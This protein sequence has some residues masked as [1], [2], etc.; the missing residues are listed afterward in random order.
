MRKWG[1]L[2]VSG[3]VLAACASLSAGEADKQYELSLASGAGLAMAWHGGPGV[4]NAIFVQRLDAAAKPKSAPVRLT[5]G[6]K[7]AYEP[8]LQ[9]IGGDL[10]VVWYE[11]DK[12]AGSTR[13]FLA[14]LNA[15]GGIVW[16]SP[17]DA[18]GG[19]ARNAVVRVSG[20]KIYAAWIETGANGPEVFA[21]TLS[22]QGDA[23]GKALRVGAAN[24]DTWNLNATTDAGGVLYLAYDAQLGTKGH[25]LQVVAVDGSTVKSV[26]VSADDGRASL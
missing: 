2:L 5:D 8:D 4:E 10:L 20:D 24:K 25:E 6:T 23:A 14:R 11:K 17:L 3:L 7:D 19:N 13:A 21:E 18:G 9:L 15:A 16:K 1:A 26:T 22:A 12:T